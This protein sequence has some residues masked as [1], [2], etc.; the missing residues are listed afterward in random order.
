VT[1]VHPF[2]FEPLISACTTTDASFDIGNAH[3]VTG[4]NSLRVLL[5]FVFEKADKSFRIDIEVRQGTMFMARWESDLSNLAQTSRCRG[6][7]RG[8]ERASTSGHLD[9]PQ[10]SHHRIVTYKLASLNT[11]VQYQADACNCRCEQLRSD[12]S[13]STSRTPSMVMPVASSHRL[14]LLTGGISHNTSCLVEIKSRETRS[15]NTHDILAQM[16]LSQQPTMFMGRH[17]RGSFTSTELIEMAEE[18]KAWE[19]QSTLQLD[20]SATLLSELYGLVS[21]TTKQDDARRFSLLYLRDKDPNV[22]QLVERRGG[23]DMLAPEDSAFERNVHGQ[24]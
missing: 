11:I 21:A 4:A 13:T 9:P 16:W 20:L 19:T 18:T 14:Q 2:R 22:L 17:S 10:T 15:Q 1:Q 6:Y 3:I 7:G 12:G 5:N 23:Q 8:F 24:A